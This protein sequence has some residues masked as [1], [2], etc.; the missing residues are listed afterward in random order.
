MFQPLPFLLLLLSLASISLC[1]DTVYGSINA[2]DAMN[3]IQQNQPAADGSD[4]TTRW[5]WNPEDAKFDSAKKAAANPVGD[6]HT[7][8]LDPVNAG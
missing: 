1:F 2:E 7:P 5:F 3:W 6:I 8:W 4:A